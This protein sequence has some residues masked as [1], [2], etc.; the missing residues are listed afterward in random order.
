MSDLMIS[1]DLGT[2]RLKVAAYHLD[3]TLAHLLQKRHEDHELVRESGS[4]RWQHAEGWWSDTVS[5]VRRLLADL[6]N[7]RVLGISLSGRGGAAVFADQS[8]EVIADPWADNRHGEQTRRLVDW[9][10]QG[11]HLSNH[12]SNYGLQLIAKYLWLHE[13]H[14]DA[15]REIHY[16]FYAKDWLLFRLCG[17][18]ITDWTSGPDADQWDPGLEA[19]DLP[20]SLLPRPALPWSV[21]GTLT[22]D[23]AAALDLPPTTPVAVGAHDG[24]AANIGAGAIEPGQFAITLGTHA[25]VRAVQ[26]DQPLGSYRF[27]GFP[28]D[29]HIIGGNAV[30]AG[31]S[32]DWFLELLEDDLSDAERSNSYQK[33]EESAVLVPA[34]ADGVRFLPFLAG[35]V[36]PEARPAARALFAGL[37]L[38]HGSA[39]LY[40]AVLE[41]SSFAVKAIFDQ[42][43][44]WCG[45]PS[46]LRATGGGAE[47]PLWMEILANIINEP[48]ELTGAGVEGRGAAMCL[49]VALG[50]HADL[51]AAAQDMVRVSQVVAPES[52]LVARYADVYRDWSRLNELSRNFD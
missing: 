16:G 8:G 12:L 13:Q 50:I 4:R 37:G 28:P 44:G 49:A 23:A 36:A 20:R 40:R 22:E 34:G 41:G 24:L 14:P 51:P 1:I 27:Y 10:R 2:T 32:A 17:E 26:D 30:L 29:R 47:S 25:V 31:R 6:P 9:R 45:P 19:F 42:V 43:S 46:M 11:A 48:V 21:A 15:A 33:A 39:E 38:S 7:S 35:Q 3:G 52:S 5:L 18:H